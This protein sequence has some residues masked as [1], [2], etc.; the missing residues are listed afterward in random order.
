MKK[1]YYVVLAD[2]DQDDRELFIEALCNIDPEIRTE[3]VNDGAQLLDLLKE[4]LMTPDIIFLDLNM[5]CRNGHECLEELR[6]FER[7]K[8]TPVVIYSTSSRPEDVE[9]TYR[10][11][12]N[13]YIKK[14]NGYLQIEN[15]LRK[16]LEL[17]WNDYLPVPPIEHYIINY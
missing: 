10:L 9:K 4:P 17:D 5:P 15:V 6:S 1:P 7:Y 13:L 8:R 11:G 14:P 2:D 3:T 16:V 12:A